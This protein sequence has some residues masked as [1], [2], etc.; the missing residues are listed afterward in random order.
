MGQLLA[1]DLFV[2][3][4]V[5]SGLSQDRARGDFERVGNPL[6]A[7]CVGRERS[8]LDEERAS[9]NHVG[10]TQTHLFAR[11]EV[12]EKFSPWGGGP[13]L[14]RFTF[15]GPRARVRIGVRAAFA[16]PTKRVGVEVIFLTT[17]ALGTFDCNLFLVC[18]LSH[19]FFHFRSHF[20]SFPP[21][22][23]SFERRY[24]CPVR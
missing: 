18:F 17:V 13:T 3:L 14:N 11:L 10:A 23:L 5:K 9:R 22:V 8:V 20:T 24:F 21:P 7:F 2:F 4:E 16:V 1:V 12:M 19:I 15:F 6:N